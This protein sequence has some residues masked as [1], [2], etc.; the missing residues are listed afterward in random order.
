MTAIEVKSA[1]EMRRM[2]AA[3]LVVA[4]GLREMAKAATVG[5]TTG[6]L[7][8]IGR[9][10]LK[11]AGADS[12]FLGYG[13]GYQT[14]FP[15]VAC[16][17]VNE[18]LVHGV[19]GA[20]V[21]RE[22]DVVSIDFGAVVAG[23]HADAAVT[24]VV[25][26]GAA[27]DVQLVEATRGALWAGIAATRA[28]GRV[29]EI[30]RAIEEHVLTRSR[31]YG[32]LREYT[33]HGIGRAMHM[34]PDVPNFHRMRRT[35]RLGVGMVLAI[36]PMLTLGSHRTNVLDDDWTVVSVDGSRGAHWEHT[37]AIT[38]GGLWVLTAPDGG[39]ADL[40]ASGTPFGPLGD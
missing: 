26:A 3:G 31:A 32:T 37:V 7:D 4:A 18:E 1:A 17:S 24:V 36:E 35:P 2:R 12:N 39:E 9:D 19:P 40:L 10:V 28:G 38:E 20:R 23:W 27:D 21:L 33:G 14:P 34:E 13:G 16:I 5:T 29:G 25:G 15:A 8:T 6:D 11:G 30:S 22:G